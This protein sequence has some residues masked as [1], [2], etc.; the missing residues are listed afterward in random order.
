M[1]AG[2]NHL[3]SSIYA[4]FQSRLAS[5]GGDRGVEETWNPGQE[6]AWLQP[7]FQDDQVPLAAPLIAFSSNTA[8]LYL[9]TGHIHLLLVLNI[10]Q[11][12]LKGYRT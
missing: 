8:G 10:R 2:A 3:T 9:P 12:T 1:S 7:T 5:R 4:S 6:S 11:K